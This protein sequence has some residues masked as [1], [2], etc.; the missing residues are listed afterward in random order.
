M[1]NYA[2]VH[3]V[4]RTRR[5]Q[6][7]RLVREHYLREDIDN[8]LRLAHFHG[9][10]Q[11]GSAGKPKE[12][13][14]VTLDA[15]CLPY[16][17][18]VLERGAEEGAITGV[19]LYSS[20]V[21]AVR[22]LRGE[23]AK[24]RVLDLFEGSPGRLSIFQDDHHAQAS[25]ASIPPVKGESREERDRRGFARACKWLV[26]NANGGVESS[27]MEVDGGQS[28]PT[29]CVLVAVSD[30]STVRDYLNSSGELKDLAS[31]GLV[32][33]K[34][35]EEWISKAHPH[36]LDLVA[37]SS[38]AAGEEEAGGAM[39]TST[40]TS[41]FLPYPHHLS[42]EDA[43]RKIKQGLCFK[44]KI[45]CTSR[46]SPWT[47]M[48]DIKTK[49]SGSSDLTQVKVLGRSSLNRAMD[50]DLVCVELI[51]APTTKGSGDPKDASSSE[52]SGNFDVGL[53]TVAENDAEG[54]DE[55]SNAVQH[56]RVVCVL[57]RA[58][59]DKGYT[60]SIQ[61]R[62]LPQSE[63]LLKNPGRPIGVLFQPS[64]RRLPLVRLRTRQANL[65]KD[66]RIIVVVDAWE[67]DSAYPNGHY[68]RALGTIGERETETKVILHQHDIADPGMPHSF[69]RST[70]GQFF[71]ILPP[72]PPQTL[73][74]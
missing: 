56:A 74:Y 25:V 34:S 48:V 39:P 3:G 65:L 29:S 18:D 33:I 24:R 27:A 44:G 23:S 69:F 61:P 43:E 20:V 52:K 8:P 38:S 10:E 42:I 54:D 70:H 47:A 26:E 71:P 60:G 17:V 68:V 4:K 32:R 30:D 67:R 46:Y 2:K 22:R 57:R 66:Q 45:K 49:D 37:L 7:V 53:A 28:A 31:A 6:V 59:R 63:S 58:W 62:S 55:V 64:D 41:S 11:K 73:L 36:L 9:S 72:K 51:D 50:G 19:V 16:Q 5:N 12:E 35:T 40:S 13:V 21:E 1:V 14:Y 15:S